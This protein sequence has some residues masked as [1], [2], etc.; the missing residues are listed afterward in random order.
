M[1][2][3]AYDGCVVE[4]PGGVEAARLK[5][6]FSPGPV[7]KATTHVKTYTTTQKRTSIFEQEK[8]ASGRALQLVIQVSYHER[9]HH[10]VTAAAV[11]Q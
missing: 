1:R 3:G 11:V 7:R 5:T 9:L 8:D 6:E 2:V 10:G 4:D